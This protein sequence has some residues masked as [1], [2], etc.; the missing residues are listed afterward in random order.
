MPLLIKLRNNKKVDCKSIH[1]L[2]Y[3]Y[4]VQV[5]VLE[6]I[7][8]ARSTTGTLFARYAHYNN[9]LFSTHSTPVQLYCTGVLGVPCMHG[10]VVQFTTLAV[11]Y[12]F[13]VFY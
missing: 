6:Y 8:G 11:V 9:G 5:Q 1:F 4:S 3:K 13:Y 2:D 7:Y 12:E 10:T